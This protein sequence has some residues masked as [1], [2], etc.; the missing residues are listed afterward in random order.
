MTLH[1][2]ISALFLAGAML[3]P[4]AAHAQSMPNDRIFCK[5][6]GLQMDGQAQCV[7]QL[8]NTTSA[9][10]RASVQATWVSR[11][12]LVRPWGGSLYEP[13]VDSNHLNGTPGT[14]YQDKPAFIPNTVAREIERAVRTVTM[15]PPNAYETGVIE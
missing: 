8:A 15:N 13:I 6:I 1:M 7:A 12:P 2:K 4:L 5:A 10:D 3:A 9:D 14:P 11:S